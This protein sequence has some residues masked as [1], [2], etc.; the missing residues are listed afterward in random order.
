M[1]AAPSAAIAVPRVSSSGSPVI[2]ATAL[3][4]PVFSAI[5]AITTGRATRIA[6]HSNC[7]AWKDGRPIQSA[8]ATPERSSRQ[9]STASG[10]PTAEW[11]FP[12]TRSKSAEIA[13]P[14]ISPRK[15]AMRDQNPR[16]H[17]TARPVNSMVSS[18]VHWSCGQYV[19]AVT[20]ARLKPIS[21]TTAPVTTGGIAVWM[22]RAPK[23]CTASPATNRAAPTT[24]TAPVT[25]ALS[26]PDARIAAATPTN[27]SEQPRYEGT[28]PRVA[29]R[30]TIVAMP[31]IMMARLGSRPM[32]TGAT[33]LAPNIATT[34]W[35]PSPAVRGHDSRSS[36]RTTAPG[37]GVRPSP[38]R[39]QRTPRPM[40][41]TT[42]VE[43][44]DQAS[45]AHRSSEPPQG[46]RYITAGYQRLR[47]D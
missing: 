7:G 10:P 42:S 32:S 3:M 31:D 8:S 11:I 46:Q 29:S 47:P 37:A 40:C 30:K 13:Y 4:C 36:G 16:R 45:W 44:I 23:R 24:N 34:C 38:C 25:T 39:V 43:S 19:D 5:R 26:P 18:A 35:A 2:S 33:K 9:W 21:I 27:D 1:E 22:I 6:D 14:K 17:T 15:I 41:P 12:K 20:G 28:R